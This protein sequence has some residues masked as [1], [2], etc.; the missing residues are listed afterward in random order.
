MQDDE[1]PWCALV[2]NSNSG[3]DST[4]SIAGD[5]FEIGRIAGADRVLDNPAIST[6]HC[7]I[8]RER[9]GGKWEIYLRD[10]SQNGVFVGEEKIGKG[11]K[12]KLQEGDFVRLISST[13]P[14]YKQYDLSYIFHDLTQKTDRELAMM[15]DISELYF[16]DQEIGKGAHASVKLGIH[17]ATGKHVAI[18]IINHQKFEL[19]NS[20]QIPIEEQVREVDILRRISH[21]NA[22]RI[23]D[24]FPQPNEMFIVM[25]YAAGGNLFD[26]IKARGRITEDDS[27]VIM[28]QLCSVVK[29]LHGIGVAHRD[30]KPENI[31]LASPN[32]VL[33]IRLTDFG[34]A[35]MFSDFSM[36]RTTCGTPLYLAPE[37]LEKSGSYTEAVDIWSLGVVLWVMLTASRP[38]PKTHQT[39]RRVDYSQSLNFST[40]P[41]PLLSQDVKD[42]LS[43]AIRVLPAERFTIFQMCDHSWLSQLPNSDQDSNSSS[44]EEILITSKRKRKKTK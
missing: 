4:I 44:E 16:I 6:H 9:V 21:K 27:K 41:L 33:K 19:S 30:I 12:V 39:S 40:P 24:V 15:R 5:K 2:P 3:S 14:M 36:L 42:F 17:K 35:K 28:K 20:E 29:Y 22:I 34:L 38:F 31:L 32:D 43:G 7:V 25:D 23:I 8:E 26:L 11:N 1:Y 13:I 37:V 10:L 18:K